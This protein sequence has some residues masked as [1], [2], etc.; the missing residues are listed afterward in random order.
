MRVRPYEQQTLPDGLIHRIFEVNTEDAELLWHRDACDREVTF[1]TGDGWLLQVAPG[2][3]AQIVP[4]STV[5]IPRDVWHRLLH[6][7][8]GPLHCAI[9]EL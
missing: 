7:G 4:G 1:I 9:R 6:D 3:P 5:R 8:G 2:L